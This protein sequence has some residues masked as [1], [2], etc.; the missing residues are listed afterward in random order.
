VRALFQRAWIT[1]LA[2]CTA[3]AFYFLSLGPVIWVFERWDLERHPSLTKVLS[4]VYAPME[5][6]KEW[7]GLGKVLE[8]YLKIW[9]WED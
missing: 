5:Q 4:T 6:V 7:P 3:F 1:L 9:G 8:G 2:L